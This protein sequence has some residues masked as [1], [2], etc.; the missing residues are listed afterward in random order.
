MPRSTN[1]YTIDACVHILT[2]EGSDHEDGNHMDVD[3]TPSNAPSSSNSSQNRQY[4]SSAPSINET[5]QGSLSSSLLQAGIRNDSGTIDAPLYYADFELEHVHVIPPYHQQG[6]PP[7]ISIRAPLVYDEH[8][9][10][11]EE[12]LPDQDEG[13]DFQDFVENEEGACGDDGSVNDESL[14]ALWTEES[15][16][17]GPGTFS[18]HSQPVYAYRDLNS[19]DRFEDDIARGR[20]RRNGEEDYPED[21]VNQIGLYDQIPPGF[22]LPQDLLSMGDGFEES[23]T[24]TDPSLDPKS[25]V[26]I[27]W[28]EAGLNVNYETRGNFKANFS[29]QEAQDSYSLHENITRLSPPVT[30][31][32]ADTAT[33]ETDKILGLFFWIFVP[34]F[35]NQQAF[36]TNHYGNTVKKMQANSGA[37]P[38]WNPLPGQPPYREF[39]NRWKDVNIQDLIIFHALLIGMACFQYCGSIRSYWRQE[40]LGAIPRA[41]F[42]HY[43]PY[44][45]FAEIVSALHITNAFSWMRDSR[46]PERDKDRL[47]YIR[48]LIIWLNK[49]FKEAVIPGALWAYDEGML[50]SKHLYNCLRQYMPAKPTKWGVKV[51]MLCC[52]MTYICYNFEIYAGIKLLRLY[53]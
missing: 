15:N 7:V 30:D 38:A 8:G 44:R 49:R 51:F 41:G 13:F 18:Y 40:H 45:R 29:D 14:E 36:W 6:S 35:W 17:F 19:R 5:R 47:W 24:N 27:Q 28:D 53:D 11:L 31:I 39:Y 12:T 23:K 37:P 42:G 32:L 34:M 50:A 3:H 2:E 25:A 33:S 46:N 21:P 26:D 16:C 43:M 52:S 4:S 9:N 1:I 20:Y 48:P 10:I 22:E